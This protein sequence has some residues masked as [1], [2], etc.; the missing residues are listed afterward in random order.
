MHRGIAWDK[1]E[2]PNPQR[3]PQVLPSFEEYNP[4]VTHPKDVE[5][6]IGI[7]I[8]VEP[9]HEPQL[10]DLGLNTYNHDILLSSREVSSFDEPK[11]QP[12]SLPNCPP[13]DV[14][15]G[16]KRVT[17]PPIKPHSSDSF[18]MKADPHDHIREFLTICDMF[19]YG[20][21]QSE[22]VKLLIFPLSLCDKAKIS[23]NELNE[24][25]I[26]SWKQLKRVFINRFFSPSL[27]NYHLLEIG[28]FSQNVCENEPT[29]GILDE[30]AGGVFL[31]KSPNQAFQF[32]KD[33][34]LF[35][36]DWSTKSQ[37][38]HHQK[39]V[40]FADS[41]KEEMHEMRKNYNNCGGD[42]GS[43]NDDTPICERHEANY[44]QSESYQNRNSHDSY[45][46]QSHHDPND[47]KKSLT[48]LNNDVTN[49]LK[50]FKRCI[51][52]IRTVHDKLFDRD[53]LSKTNL[54][55]SIIKFLDGQR[56]ASMYI[57]NNVNDIITKMKQSENNYQTVRNKKSLGHF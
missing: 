3:T 32:L 15:L 41:L 18:R 9:L 52:S 51:R 12:Q 26:T 33:K 44:I 5:E 46:H 47:S 1:V 13:F 7:P 57:K 31:Y 37:N 6:A 54:E 35:K 17:D 48:K 2:N 20:K 30:T 14:N 19:K 50:D 38:E 24:E 36:L 53:D 39:S 21:T 4:L 45:S 22:A 27:F 34:V 25:S 28:N 55:K 49:D 8:E 42:H 56:V 43:K 23:F 29:Q 10:E 16:D 40:A 11:P